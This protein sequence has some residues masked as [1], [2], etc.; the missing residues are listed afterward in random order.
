VENTTNVEYFT[1]PTRQ[2]Q[3]FVA[4]DFNQKNLLATV[5][6]EVDNDT[7]GAS[8]GSFVLSVRTTHDNGEQ[9]TQEYMQSWTRDDD[10]PVTFSADYPIEE[11]V[12]LVVRAQR[13]RCTCAAAPR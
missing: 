5:E 1:V 4:L 10:Q 6:G 9:A 2:C 8:S 13:V 12:V 7:C 11:D 3:A